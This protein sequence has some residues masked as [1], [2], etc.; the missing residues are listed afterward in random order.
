[1]RKNIALLAGIVSLSWPVFC[2]VPQLEPKLARG[3]AAIDGH[4]AY[5]SC[6]TLAA[7]RFE[8]RLSGSPG[9]TAAARWAALKFEDWGLEAPA[10]GFLQPF[11]SPYTLV[12]KAE[13]SFA[14]AGKESKL[15]PGKDFL[16]LLFSAPGRVS[17]AVVFAGWGISAPELGYDDYA[18]VDV[19]G[20]FVLCF[21]GTP[22]ADDK[23]FQHYDEHRVRMRAA[24]DKGALG[25][26]YIYPEVQANPNGEFL[27]NF[28]PAMISE[29]AADL[30]LEPR[31]VKALELKKTLQTYGVPITFALDA[32]VDF[33][34][35][36]RH[37]ADGIG[38]NVAA[39]L[40]GSDPRLRDE[41]VILGAHL[42]GC[43]RHL[44]ILFPGADDN[45]SGSAV[46][47]ELAR[48]FSTARIRPRRS[49]LFVLFGGEEMGLLGATH[50]AQHLPAP[51]K[52][53]S[54]MF[55]FD[56]EGEG[57]RAFAQLS[58]EPAALKADI[59]RADASVQIIDGSSFF[60]GV[61]VRSSDF[62]P[63]FLQ[64]IPCAAFYANGPHV[65]YHANGD[66]I[67]RINPDILGAIGRLAFLSTWFW[68]ERL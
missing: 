25:L 39:Y 64:G 58:Q 66:S 10:G 27:E 36:A 52:K 21:R 53:I 35:E 6:R 54:A 3:L 50:F 18:G 31:K 60:K 55:N 4:A 63:F 26:I 11:S 22:D 47:M 68:A 2:A 28:M 43:G 15:Q 51:I 34:V 65:Q 20:K 56:M 17:G 57:D 13:M 32:R 37:F 24:R 7:D 5:E 16:P 29:A 61:G 40:Q 9:Y 48:A 62:A 41:Y 30:L 33:L 49:I 19:R 46:V 42:D 12:D 67:F 23:R 8:G 1:M 44:G 14:V 45:A 59:E 38:Y